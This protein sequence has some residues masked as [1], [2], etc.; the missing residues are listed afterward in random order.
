MYAS[1]FLKISLA[2]LV[3]CTSIACSK[4]G[5]IN[6]AIEVEIFPVAESVGNAANT[7]IY[8]LVTD[9]LDAESVNVNT[10][11]LEQLG[12]GEPVEVERVVAVGQVDGKTKVSITPVALLA[13]NTQYQVTLRAEEIALMHK[14]GIIRPEWDEATPGIDHGS[15]GII[16]FGKSL[17]SRTD[18]EVTWSFT[19]GEGG[20]PDVG[21]PGPGNEKAGEGEA[22]TADEDCVE[23]LICKENVCAQPEKADNNEA[24][25]EDADC[26][27]GACTENICCGSNEQMTCEVVNGD[28]VCLGVPPAFACEVK[29][30]AVPLAG[31][32]AESAIT[33]QL[34]HQG[35]KTGEIVA[36][37]DLNDGEPVPKEASGLKKTLDP[38]EELGGTYELKAPSLLPEVDSY[39]HTAYGTITTDGD[40]TAE[41]EST[42]KVRKPL[43]I[44]NP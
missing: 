22:C 24:C 29:V 25:E 11:L 14:G 42:F 33:I 26:L 21:L 43:D 15:K 23:G 20:V 4:G 10:V 1:R 12:G 41:C 32:D 5:E 2:L 44:A 18:G 9:P 30:L 40:M 38:L 8:A 31:V 19:V 3:L 7:E 17:A 37:W 13:E 16:S 6:Q 27:L 36:G 39:I 28:C 34:T 35:G